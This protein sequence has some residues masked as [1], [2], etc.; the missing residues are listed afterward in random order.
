M[1]QGLLNFVP[2]CSRQ[3]LV[4]EVQKAHNRLLLMLYAIL[5]FGRTAC[6]PGLFLQRLQHSILQEPSTSR[7]DFQIEVRDPVKH[8]DGV[9]VCVF[10]SSYCLKFVI[11]LTPKAR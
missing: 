10:S 3:A 7:S 6:M 2:T 9:S 8:G 5:G 11:I 1:C 4:Q